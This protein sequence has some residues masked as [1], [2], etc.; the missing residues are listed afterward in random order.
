[1][2]HA[3]VLSVLPPRST[4]LSFVILYTPAPPTHVPQSFRVSLTDVPPAFVP[5]P[6]FPP[7]YTTPT[8]DATV[9]NA[10]ARPFLQYVP[11]I[12]N[13]NTPRA[14]RRTFTASTTIAAF[15]S[16]VRLSDPRVS[17]SLPPPPYGLPGP[18]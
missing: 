13:N 4:C 1:M 11:S 15:G 16:N 12:V 3:Y 17:P 8:S 2:L 6:H 9:A 10:N 5:P 18:R 7:D 14:V